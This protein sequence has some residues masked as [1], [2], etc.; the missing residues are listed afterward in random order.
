MTSD[1]EVAVVVA[2]AVVAVRPEELVEE[3]EVAAEEAA[4]VV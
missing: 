4:E 2:E 3:I 1:E